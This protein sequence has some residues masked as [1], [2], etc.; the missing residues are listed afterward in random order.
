MRW[1]VSAPKKHG[2]EVPGNHDHDGGDLHDP[3]GLFAGLV[4]T[5]NVCSN[6]PDSSRTGITT[7]PR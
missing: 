1:Q 5:F 3:H 7:S 4:N 6:V 2:I